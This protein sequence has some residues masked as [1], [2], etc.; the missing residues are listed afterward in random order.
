[1]ISIGLLITISTLALHQHNV[2][3]VVITYTLTF[4]VLLATKAKK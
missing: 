4:L 1:M 3:D 2:A